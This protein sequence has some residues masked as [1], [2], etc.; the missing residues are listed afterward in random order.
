MKFFLYPTLQLLAHMRRPKLAARLLAM[1]TKPLRGYAHLSKTS[2]IRL[3][4][5]NL[6]KPGFQEDVDASFLSDNSFQL[7]CWP[8]YA[9]KA[10]ASILLAPQLNNKRYASNDPAIEAS[11]QDYREFL[12]TMWAHFREVKPVDAVISANFGYFAQREFGAALKEAGTPLIVLHKENVKSPAR[13]EY[14]DP[15][16]RTR[17]TFEGNK[18]LVYNDTERS[19]QIR[20]G[21]AEP[22]QIV[23]TGMPRLDRI[24][25]WRE[26][27]AEAKKAPTPPTVLLFSFW[28]KEKL[29]ATER[30]TADRI[31]VDDADDEWSGLSWNTLC[32]QTH[33]A[34]VEVAR[35]RPDARVII[36]T[37]AFSRR[38]EDIL[39]ILTDGGADLPANVKVVSGGD[40]F[41]LIKDSS[42]VVGFNTTALLEALAAGK[43]VIVPNFAEATDERMRPLVIDVGS[44]AARPQS[45]QELI[46]M[47]C[48]CLDA[49]MPSSSEISPNVGQALRYWVGNDDGAAGK[50]VRQAVLREI[51][52]RHDVQGIS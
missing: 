24:H 11:K 9:L 33:R 25:E 4:A 41:P 30:I 8:N 46:D 48:G 28:R 17:G 31:R 3:L 20:T 47:I 2:H 32:E 26:S 23:V 40:P 36:K 42:V 37:K 6:N 35:R 19:L 15:I 45:Q 50:R 29:T 27:H 49:P 52:Y 43:P 51:A 18:I 5:L 16:Y 38:V 22:D 12:S 21:V 14:W 1:S 39:G 44:A 34:V 7:F 10:V 13:V